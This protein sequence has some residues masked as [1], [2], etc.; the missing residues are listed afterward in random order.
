M[1]TSELRTLNANS[2]APDPPCVFKN[3]FAIRHHELRDRV[4]SL[5]SV[6]LKKMAFGCPLDVGHWGCVWFGLKY[7]FL[8]NLIFS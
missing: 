8:A 7:Q 5:L 3:M 2:F 4:G 1:V 6:V